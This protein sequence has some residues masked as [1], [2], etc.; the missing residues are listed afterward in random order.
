[1]AERSEAQSAKNEKTKKREF[2]MILSK[3]A[4]SLFCALVTA[5]DAG[6]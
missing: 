2:F 6:I 1:M 4:C 3:I 5:D